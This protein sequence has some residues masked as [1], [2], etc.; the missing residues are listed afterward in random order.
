MKII[1][2]YYIKAI[3]FKVFNLIQIR[4]TACM[5]FLVSLADIVWL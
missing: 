2:M 5:A 4:V 3:A 1:H